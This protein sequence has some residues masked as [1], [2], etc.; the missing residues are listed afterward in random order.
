MHPKIALIGRP[1]VGKSTLFN[2]LIRSNRAITHDRPGVTRDRMEGTVKREG[3][4]WTVID[5]GGIHLDENHKATEGPSELRGFEADILRQTQEAVSEC[6]ALCLVVDGREG[7]LPFD[8]RLADY[9]R[10]SGLPVLLAVNKVDGGELE[11]ILTAEFHELGLPMV[12][13]SGEH[14]YNMRAFEEELRAML[15]A[16]EEWE[17]QEEEAGLKLAMLGRP[18][19]GKSSLVN[20][21]TG[22]QRMIVSDVAGTTRDSVDVTCSLNGK[23]Y[24]FVDTAGV[25]RRSKI[26]DSVER[27]SVNSS[28]KSSTKAHVTILVLDGQEGLTQQDKRLIDLLDE[29][30]TPFMVLVNKTDL[31]ARGDLAAV[32]KVYQDALSYCAHVPILYVSAHSGANLKRIIPL[33]EQIW[34][35]GQVRVPTGQLNRVLEAIVT[36]QQPPVVNRVRPKFFYMTQAETCP[37]TFVFFVNDAERLKDA[38][39][40]YMERSLRKAFKIVHAPVRVRF[41]S[42]HTKREKK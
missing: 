22:G 15:P 36:K 31:I 33:A 5:T 9:V 10:R 11:D 24:T 21:L 12:A 23:R 34:S 42:S 14:G 26:V 29:R 27:Y 20:A 16:E 35:E 19:A 18:N 32:K 30:K 25:R 2:R 17:R 6:V 13:L 39:I 41:R 4:T 28:I 8:R 38:Y 37:P 7:L 3:R 40:R 1:N